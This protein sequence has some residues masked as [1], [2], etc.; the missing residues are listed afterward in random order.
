MI[1]GQIHNIV[2][3][4]TVISEI[5]SILEERHGKLERV[6]VAAAGRALK[7]MEG[8]MTI[9]IVGKP[10]FTSED[11]NRLELAAVQVAQQKLLSTATT[12][13]DYYYCVGYSVLHYKLDGDEIGSLID[14]AGR[15]ATAE[16]I[17]T[18]L[19][20]VVVES[21][22]SALKRAGLEMEALTL[23]PI[24]A[25]NVLIPP[26]MRRLN[27]ALV[28]IGAGTSDI[29]I[30]D[31][32][33]VVSYGMVPIA[34]DEITEALSNHFLL[35]FPVAESAKRSLSTNEKITILDIL[36]F[37]QQVPS[38]EV[39]AIIKPAIDKLASSIADEII[40][41]NNNKSPQAVMVVGGGSLTP[42]LPKELSSRLDLPENRVGIRALDALSDI[43]LSDGIVSTPALVTPIG[44][45]IAARRAPIHYMSVNVNEKTIRLFELKEM[46]VG[47]ALLAANIK[48]RQLYGKPGMGMSMTLNGELMTI[49]GEHGRSAKIV[50]NGNPA[51]TKDL[52]ANG[53]EI[54]LERGK[55][56]KDASL[57]IRELIGDIRPFEVTVNGNKHTIVPT[58]ECNGEPVELDAA[59]HDRDQVVYS[60]STKL[61]DVL[62]EINIETSS[63]FEVYINNKRILLED[64]STTFL[65]NDLPVTPQHPLKDGDVV[66]FEAH[67]SPTVGEVISSLDQPTRSV[68]SITFNG[69]PVTITD[70]GSSILLNGRRVDNSAKVL[71]GDR[72]S[73]EE[74]VHRPFLFSDIFLFIDY[75]LPTTAP[76]SYQLLRNGEPIGFNDPIFSGDALEI[77]F[78]S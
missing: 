57:T 53:D 29:A 14:Q 70:S 38:A 33:T 64:W 15:S 63:P 37:E 77:K 74:T 52:I 48:A 51:S 21:L 13:D 41:L 56:G 24:A 16:V 18:F 73:I 66:Q 12:A 9:D 36:G 42:L 11:I 60:H 19:P 43:T 34:G 54:T 8:S 17:A 59:I 65:L 4:A 31:N 30:T 1:D 46:T 78:S 61:N 55:D 27:V 28:D 49:P 39:V 26:S 10:L 35:D 40:R 67:A 20:R 25:I 72:L 5:K 76:T 2:S 3:V 50:L 71:S 47:D 7:T 58:I 44:I 22:L 23:E 62:S 69:Q 45:A 32:N 6:S 75:S 68:A